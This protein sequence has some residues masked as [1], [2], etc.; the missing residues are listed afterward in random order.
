MRKILMKITSNKIIINRSQKKYQIQHSNFTKEDK[1]KFK[2]PIH[3]VIH[4]KDSKEIWIHNRESIGVNHQIREYHK[5]SNKYSLKFNKTVD[6]LT[7]KIIKVQKEV[8][9][10]YNKKCQK[11]TMKVFIHKI[12]SNPMMFTIITFYTKTQ[13]LVE[14]TMSSQFKT[15]INVKITPNKLMQ[16]RWRK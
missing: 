10:E 1:I 11:L 6:I 15:F 16:K 7:P 14:E 9:K 2:T 5:I 13:G 8:K 12:I 3:R 4:N